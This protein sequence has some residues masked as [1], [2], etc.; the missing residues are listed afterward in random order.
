MMADCVRVAARSV[1]VAAPLEL[2]LAEQIGTPALQLLVVAASL[3]AL[4]VSFGAPH[5]QVQ[6]RL[7][8]L[9][10]Q[11]VQVGI[12]IVQPHAAAIL[13][14]ET[15]IA[16]VADFRSGSSTCVERK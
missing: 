11:L 3:L 8:P 5:K 10:A 15:V 14:A 6:A 16:L 12:R 7:L 4:Y 13:V 9:P 1:S 2:A